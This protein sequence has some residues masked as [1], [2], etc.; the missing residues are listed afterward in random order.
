MTGH[1][2]P[3]RPLGLLA[4]GM[5]G[6]AA[7]AGCGSEDQGDVS[8]TP[9]AAVSAASA[10][11][12][13]A[14]LG[15]AEDLSA[16]LL[17]AEAFGPG[18]QVT[19][20]GADQVEQQLARFGGLGGL[21]DLEVTPEGCAAALTGT[22]PDLEDLTGFAAQS[23]VAGSTVTAEVLTAGPA[24]AGAVERLS[25]APQS[26]PQATVTTPDLGSADLTI[27]ALP[28]PDLG[29]GAAGVTVTLSLTG[30]DGGPLTVPVLV[31]MARDADRLVT[32]TTADP[33]AAPDP[34]TFGQ[35]FQDA[36]QQ[37]ADALD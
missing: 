17:A 7:L 33:T 8:D 31:G 37:Q 26:C 2:L 13:P 21:Q 18:A 1:C 24:V 4:A 27:T 28:V 9:A 22:Q 25:G 3:R 20:I 32:L 36:F 23:A 29:D 19:S 14:G 12:T 35:L 11:A 16:G 30:P 5:L 10:G 6:A 34:A 15:D